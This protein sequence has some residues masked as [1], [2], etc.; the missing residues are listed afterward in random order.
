MAKKHDS[1]WNLEDLTDADVYAAIRYLEPG[2]R[3]ANEQN[4]DTAFVIS[5]GLVILLLG[6]LAFMWLYR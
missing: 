5:F 2:P 6:C 1:K 4:G 3:T